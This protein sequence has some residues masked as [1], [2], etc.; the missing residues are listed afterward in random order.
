MNIFSKYLRGRTNKI[1]TVKMRKYMFY[2]MSLLLIP[3]LIADKIDYQLY[4]LMMDSDENRAR[5]KKNKYLN[6]VVSK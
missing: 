2:G 3:L 6:E 5:N 4:Y 1:A